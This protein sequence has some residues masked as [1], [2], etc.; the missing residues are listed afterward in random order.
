VTTGRSVTF[1]VD[2]DASVAFGTDAVADAVANAVAEAVVDAVADAVA[3][4]AADGAVG[5]V[6]RKLP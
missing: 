1:E 2:G 5:A 3:G 4:D 6:A